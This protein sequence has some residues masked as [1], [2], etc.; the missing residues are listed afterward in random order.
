M[1]GDGRSGCPGDEECDA[2]EGRPN[3]QAEGPVAR[4]D[5]SAQTGGRRDHERQMRGALDRAEAQ[6][7]RQRG[8]RGLDER[9]KGG[10]RHEQRDARPQHRA[11]GPY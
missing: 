2:H 4:R 7:Q 10:Q 6:E 9:N 11:V 3:P 1:R 5:N 8:H